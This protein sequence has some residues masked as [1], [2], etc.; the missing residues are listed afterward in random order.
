MSI[1]ESVASVAKKA[2]VVDAVQENFVA[3][4]G[5]ANGPIQTL[6]AALVI[7]NRGRLRNEEK[8]EDQFESG[9]HEVE[10]G[11]TTHSEKK[12]MQSRVEAW[13]SDPPPNWK[14]KIPKPVVLYCSR[15]ACDDCKEFASARGDYEHIHF[16]RAKYEGVYDWPCD[17]SLVKD[18]AV[19]AGVSTLPAYLIINGDGTTEV[20]TPSNQ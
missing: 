19:A 5:D 17:Q 13:Q 9:E 18:S 10:G 7:A 20:C 8:E 16:P 15:N 2:R 3:V 14:V 11:C 4:C 12:M 6:I 1:L